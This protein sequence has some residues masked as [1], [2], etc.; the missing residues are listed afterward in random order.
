[1]WSF[2]QHIYKSNAG[3]LP[4]SYVLSGGANPGESATCFSHSTTDIIV[5]S[6][7]SVLGVG[8]VLYTEMF[9]TEPPYNGGGYT[10][11]LQSEGKLVTI[12]NSGVVIALSTCV[13]DNISGMLYSF[14]V[15]SHV[16]VAIYVDDILVYYSPVVVNRSE[17]FS[18]HAN[19]GQEVRVVSKPPDHG[20]YRLTVADQ[21]STLYDSGSVYNYAATY[22]E[23]TF[24]MPSS[25]I[26]IYASAALEIA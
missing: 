2:K 19:V 1:M 6:N 22:L 4:Y 3:T 11:F 21:S 18:L 8:T 15:D 16:R 17:T 7:S 25:D 26:S 9:G 5:Y 20:F 14:S 23:F 12:N 13:P 10:Y 24:S